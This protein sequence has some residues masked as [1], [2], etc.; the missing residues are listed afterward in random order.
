MYLFTVE[1]WFTSHSLFLSLPLGLSLSHTPNCPH[2]CNSRTH[3]IT[4]L[5]MPAP[6]NLITNGLNKT[7]WCNKLYCFIETNSRQ[8]FGSQT[9]S[10]LSSPIVQMTKWR[11]LL[12][13]VLFCYVRPLNWSVGQC[14]RCHAMRCD[15]MSPIS[16]TFFR[17]RT[18]R[19]EQIVIFRCPSPRL[20]YLEFLLILVKC[21]CPVVVDV[22]RTDYWNSS[23]AYL[24]SLWCRR[25]L[26]EWTSTG[27]IYL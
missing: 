18:S 11:V 25:L 27:F 24:S 26:S 21:V 16:R 3:W 20:M 8:F 12:L 14:M 5:T 15:E 17:V 22:I 9:Q 23:S 4:C 19:A 1:R 7:K 10:L 2:T 13:V 6:W